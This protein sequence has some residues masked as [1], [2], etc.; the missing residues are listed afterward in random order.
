MEPATRVRAVAI[1]TFELQPLSDLPSGVVQA[2]S[3]ISLPLSR[4]GTRHGCGKHGDSAVC[5]RVQELGEV[6]KL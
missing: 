3:I 5:R 1:A 2:A 6:A 4:C